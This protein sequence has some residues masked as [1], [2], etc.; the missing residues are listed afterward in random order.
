MSDWMVLHGGALGD[1]ALTI[2]LALR[3]REVQ[4]GSTLQ[5]V[6]RV[7]PG[8]LSGC[9]PSIERVSP[10]GLGLHWLHMEGDEPPAETLR[11]LVAGRRVLSALGDVDSTVHRR[12]RR[13]G[14]REVYSFDPRPKPDLDAHITTQWQRELEQQGLL[15]PKCSYH[16]RGRAALAVP[17]ETRQR[18]GELLEQISSLWRST[19]GGGAGRYRTHGRASRPRH[20]VLI[21]PGGGGR[22]KCWALP[23]FLDVGRRLCAKDNDVCFVVGP[24]ETE[25]WTNAEF[26]AIRREFPLIERPEPDELLA[27][28]AA[29]ATFISNDSGPAH[30]ASLLGAPTVTIFGPTSEAVWRP[31]GP[32]VRAIQGD[33]TEDA[34]NWGIDPQRVVEATRQASRHAAR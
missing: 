34:K 13:L 19:A 16:N 31:L 10:E 32:R 12:L 30:L 21:H 6:S 26:E 5:V 28:L 7:D 27:L 4:A 20:P 2:Q 23:R 9:R 17:D 11:E 25:R 24:A 1:L 3:L 22:A 18:G 29:T 33:P 15:Y 8:D 14:A